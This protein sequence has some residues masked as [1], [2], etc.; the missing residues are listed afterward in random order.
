MK[1]FFTLLLSVATITGVAQKRDTLF[2]KSDRTL[3][4]TLDSADLIRI[5]TQ[6]DNNIKLYVI[7]DYL[8]T[9]KK[10][11][12]TWKSASFNPS[13]LDGE[14][15]YYHFNGNKKGIATY[16]EGEHIGSR[17]LFYPD[18][19]PYSTFSN[20]E[21]IKKSDA[22]KFLIVAN[23]DSLGTALVAY[24]NG[25]FKGS[26]DLNSTFYAEG[27]VKNGLKSGEW[28]YH[29]DELSRIE[30]YDDNGEIILG[31]A[32]KTKTGE[33]KTYTQHQT[34]A[35]FPGGINEFIKYLG[36]TIIYPETAKQRRIQ[37]RVLVNFI[38]EPS[39]KV[40]NV[41]AVNH[42]NSALEREAIR[43]I[44]NSPAW[45]PGY[46]YGFPVRASITTPINFSLD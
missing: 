11:F 8:K 20:P 30:K 12:M 33:T 37:G 19:K 36:N 1:P 22:S 7:N 46:Q 25:Y 14:I 45:V 39:G 23:Y 32:T 44:E 5:V 2:I 40:T 6:P 17:Y 10:L 9:S 27:A 13:R 21:K 3:V 35:I 28:K 38:V 42:I 31:K 26:E 18:G 34:S 4:S 15:T 24:G 16:K 29:N 41:T 43:V